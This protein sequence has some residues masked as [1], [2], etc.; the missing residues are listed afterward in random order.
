MGSES[1]SGRAH[2]PADA[3][4]GRHGGLQPVVAA[5]VAWRGAGRRGGRGGLVDGLG[6]NQRTKERGAKAG[7]SP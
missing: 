5:A 3:G 1:T 4:E 7:C 6:V 2:Q